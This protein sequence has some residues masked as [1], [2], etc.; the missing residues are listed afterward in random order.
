MVNIKTGIQ[1]PYHRNF[2]A[3]LNRDCLG[4][5]DLEYIVDKEYAQ[6]PVH[7]IRAFLLI[8]SDLQK[9]FEYIEPSGESLSTYSYRIHELLMR[10][11]IEIEANF[12]AILIENTYTPK[13]RD[14]YDIY[15]MSIYKKVNKTHRLSS[16]QVTLPIWNG[17]RR[18]FEPFKNW[19][20]SNGQLS[21]YQAYNASKHNRQS[22]FKQANLENLLD[23]ITALL[24]LLSAQFCTIDFSSGIIHIGSVGGCEYYK[25]YEM[26][27]SIGNYFRIKFPT[28]WS[29]EEKYNFDWAKL[30]KQENRFEK[31]NY[32]KI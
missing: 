10:T 5:S 6:S 20:E 8:Q 14:V 25:Y 21:W 30:A 19:A 12:K 24:I 18:L 27:S 29:D 2:R 16:Y 11:C 3:V 7:Y 4:H 13:K 28:D 23:A 15:N 31:I 9:L 17:E 32:N 26:D 22:G 1:K